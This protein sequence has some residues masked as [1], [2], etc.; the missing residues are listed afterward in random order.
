MS[1]EGKHI[2]MDTL[3]LSLIHIWQLQIILAAAGLLSVLATVSCTL[4]LLS[5][6]HILFPVDTLAFLRLCLFNCTDFLACIAGVKLVKPVPQGGKLVILCLLYTSPE[7]H[8]LVIFIIRFKPHYLCNIRF[9]RAAL[10]IL[11]GKLE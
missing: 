3:A 7:K 2:S 11:A 6:I 5:L 1:K 9:I 4:F 8:N 10:V